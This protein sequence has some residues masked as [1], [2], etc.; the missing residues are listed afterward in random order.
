MLS[1]RYAAQRIH[2]INRN[3]LPH[4]GANH[5]H[6]NWTAADKCEGQAEPDTISLTE[7]LDDEDAP[8]P[9]N[10]T[11]TSVSSARRL[12]H[13]FP[14]FD[15]ESKELDAEV[16]KKHISGGQVAEY[17]ETLDEED[18]ERFKKQSSTYL[19]DGVNFEEI[20]EIYT[21]A[22]AAIHEDPVVKPTE[23][24]KDRKAKS[25]KHKVKRLTL[26]LEERKAR[27]AAKMEAFK[28]TA[29]AAAETAEEGNKE[30]EEW[31]RRISSSLRES[32]CVLV[33]FHIN[34]YV[35][36]DLSASASNRLGLP[37]GITSGIFYAAG[38]SSPRCT[39]SQNT[40][41]C[42]LRVNKGA[43]DDLASMEYLFHCIR[44]RWPKSHVVVAPFNV[45]SERQLP[46]NS[47]PYSTTI[48][49]EFTPKRVCPSASDTPS[50][51]TSS[52]E[53]G[54]GVLVGRTLHAETT[55]GL[56]SKMEQPSTS[57]T[58]T[59]RVADIE[60]R[61][62]STFCSEPRTAGTSAAED[63][64]YS[65]TPAAKPSHVKSESESPSRLAPATVSTL[66][67]SNY[68]EEG[69]RCR[70][71]GRQK[72]V[73]PDVILWEQLKGLI[74][75]NMPENRMRTD[76]WAERLTDEERAR[77]TKP[78]HEVV[79]YSDETLCED[80][81]L[82]IPLQWSHTTTNPVIP[83]SLA[84]RPCVSLGVDGLLKNLNEIL[85][86]SYSL[87]APGLLPVLEGCIEHKYDF[88]TAFGRLRR[89]WF[90]DFEGL[91]ARLAERE[92]KDR[93]MR[94]DAL[95][96]EKGVIMDKR[97]APRRVWD[98]LSNRV[99]PI[100]VLGDAGVW[101]QI[102]WAISHSWMAEALR[103]YVL[104]P[105]NGYEWH[106]PLPNDIS[107][108][109]IRI[110]LLN[111]GLEYV[112]L[113]VLC[114]RQE[115]ES[116][117]EK[118]EVRKRE[119]MLDVPT[120]GNIYWE[121]Q[122]VVTYFEGLGRP[123][124][125][126]DISSPRHW[127]NRAWT[128][129]ETNPSTIIGGLTPTSPFPPNAEA[130][131]GIAK[132]FYAAFARM[133]PEINRWGDLLRL[134]QIMDKRSASYEIDKIAGLAYLT[135]SSTLPS[136]IR[137]GDEGTDPMEAAWTHLLQSGAPPL[138]HSTFD[139]RVWS[140]LL[141]DPPRLD[142]AHVLD[143]CT[144]HGL[145]QPDAQQRCRRGTLTV[146]L[147]DRE[148]GSRA[149][150]FVVT[151]HHQYPIPNDQRYTLMDLMFYEEERNLEYWIVGTRTSSG[152]VQKVSVL[153]MEDKDDRKRLYDL[154]LAIRTRGILL[155]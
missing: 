49:S 37:S 63:N 13:C 121:S 8:R 29:G 98:L 94:A 111:L 33:D 48:S 62:E 64:L 51:P 103:H 56:E 126:S 67:G 44:R 11:S 86:T 134:T 152:A 136:Y 150:R 115:D 90:G 116:R 140:L 154:G 132:Q 59:A 21:N 14:R 50:S 130:L 109:R 95:D 38:N 96:E 142:D 93:E 138:P 104:T 153:E 10:A 120:I 15:P 82:D 18:D 42:R 155:K 100:L 75:R 85:R 1:S 101:W 55:S 23:K 118:E 71:S 43:R 41:I 141:S 133:A 125:I 22:H 151:A 128:L 4:C 6:S 137:S 112:W 26:T 45:D 102:V 7:A 117:P 60:S 105:I 19:A 3:E 79:V 99:L 147:E 20:D 17:P 36:I 58:P 40:P 139:M 28:E 9:S 129:Q 16:L 61:G 91:P 135:R 32:L 39:D 143:L 46:S 5:G 53:P 131:D 119:W 149:E 27:I 114:L 65:E 87:D 25:L 78:L 106:V 97:I 84:D 124:Y 69:W 12:V 70:Y 148:R 127:L 122:N 88:G 144:I 76:Y 146:P 74:D 57:E 77:A 80:A 54:L 107:L 145:D 2:H 83:S 24:A 34:T 68:V 31:T 110:E 89:F 73:N 47:K 66:S 81:H 52:S 108:D 30:D 35:D 113:D 123:F 92:G 72:D